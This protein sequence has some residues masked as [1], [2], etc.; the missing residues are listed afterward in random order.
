ME[1]RLSEVPPNEARDGPVMSMSCTA[2]E[3]AANIGTIG[4]SDHGKTTLTAA[5]RGGGRWLPFERIN[6]L[7]RISALR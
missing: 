4:H 5:T 3:P 7:P 2:S 1:G 6:A